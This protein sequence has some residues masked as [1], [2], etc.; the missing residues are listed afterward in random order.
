MTKKIEKNK[1][2]AIILTI[3]FLSAAAFLG[4]QLMAGE[5]KVNPLDQFAQCLTDQGAKIYGAYWCSNCKIQEER[6]DSSWKFI[7]Y[8]EC[9]TP[10]IQGQVSSCNEAEIEGYPTWV[11]ADASRLVGSQTLESLSD[12]TGCDLSESN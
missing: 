6:F 12:K 3:V 5:P 2:I 11:F 9:A 7:D 1:K 4:F 10:G 8:T